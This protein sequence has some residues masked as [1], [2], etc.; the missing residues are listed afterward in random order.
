MFIFNFTQE[1]VMGYQS[2][3]VVQDGYHYLELV[4][5]PVIIIDEEYQVAYI[6]ASFETLTGFEREK[7]LGKKVWL[8][9][10][11]LQIEKAKGFFK[12]LASQEIN[13]FLF[14]NSWFDNQEQYRLNWKIHKATSP[15]GKRCYIGSVIN[16]T[17]R[18]YTRESFDTLLKVQ[19]ALRKPEVY[20]EM[21]YMPIVEVKTGLAV[22]ESLIRMK[23]PKTGCIIPPD[24]FIPVSEKSGLIIPI[25][26]WALREACRMQRKLQDI[27]YDECITVSTNIALSHFIEGEPFLDVYNAIQ[28]TGANPQRLEIE[29]TETMMHENKE[30]VIEV[31]H[32]LSTE[33]NIAT[34]MDDFGTGSA[35]ISQTV[36][37]Y[38]GIKIDRT[39]VWQMVKEDAMRHFIGQTIRLYQKRGIK[40]IAEGIETQEQFMML[41]RM[42]CRYFQ[43]YYFGKAVPQEQALEYAKT[44]PWREK[45]KVA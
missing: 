33:L 13:E 17:H 14:E 4:P 16:Q 15:E 18:L 32:R 2:C 38:G 25:G 9:L 11:R 21:H 28:E 3:V 1:V 39:L 19:K 29:L 22:Y 34:V 6:N 27:D 31:M 45:L 30:R 42:G 37:P 26:Q 41:Y 23:D 12:K 10:D 8:L 5:T 24:D 44:Q 40:V 35:N 7:V 36:L 43:G 20:F